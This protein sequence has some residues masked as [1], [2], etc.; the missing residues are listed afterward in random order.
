MLDYKTLHYKPLTSATW[1][2]FR[3][4]GVFIHLLK[5]A[6]E[7]C[8]FKGGAILEGYP[9]EPKKDKMPAV[10]AWTG[11]ASAY[12]KVGFKEVARRSETR[13][14]MRFYIP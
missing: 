5:F 7:Y 3:R 9:V 8:R 10:F 2:A 13:P 1:K 14:V 11:I 6:I 4:Q 12:L